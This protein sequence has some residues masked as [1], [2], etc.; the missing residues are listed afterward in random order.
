MILQ[1]CCGIRCCYEFARCDLTYIK[2]HQIFGHVFIKLK[3]E[4]FYYWEVTRSITDPQFWVQ[5][6]C[7]SNPKQIQ[8]LALLTKHI[9]KFDASSSVTY[10]I[11]FYKTLY[12]Q[13]FVPRH[14]F[15]QILPCVLDAAA[16]IF[17]PHILAAMKCCVE[18]IIFF[19]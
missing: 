7:C 6:Y 1:T 5:W 18:L 15:L 14:Q 17:F 3:Y 11:F 13:V 4:S 2:M 8:T 10:M 16:T 19:R 9:W 12:R